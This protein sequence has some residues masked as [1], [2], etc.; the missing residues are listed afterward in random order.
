MHGYIRR[1]RRDPLQGRGHRVAPLHAPFHHFGAGK[2]D[3]MGI[4]RAEHFS[5][6][7]GDHQGDKID[8]PCSC[9]HVFDELLVAR[10][11]H[12]PQSDPAWKIEVGKAEFDRDAPFL[13]LFETVRVDPCQRPHKG[14]LSMVDMTRS[15]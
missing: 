14:G 8:P 11:V 15:P 3:Q 7:R 10:D 5:I 4:A 2:G 12:D 9:N 1:R 13:F 6:V